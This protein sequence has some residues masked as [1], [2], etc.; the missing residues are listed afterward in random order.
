MLNVL[1]LCSSSKSLKDAQSLGVCSD[2]FQYKMRAPLSMKKIATST[3][4]ICKSSHTNCVSHPT[5]IG[6]TERSSDYYL[7]F[8]PWLLTTNDAFPPQPMTQCQSEKLN[9]K[10]WY[11]Y[12]LKLHLMLEDTSKL[13]ATITKPTT[14]GKQTQQAQIFVT[15]KLVISYF[16][17]K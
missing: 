14:P 3:M 6:C 7:H 2:F 17:L 13:V 12:R 8:T 1:Q 16:S 9:Q 10:S 15:W 4:W 11:R 5:R